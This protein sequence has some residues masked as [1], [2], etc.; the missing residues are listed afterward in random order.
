MLPFHLIIVVMLLLV[1]V[2][3]AENSR[4]S[5]PHIDASYGQSSSKEVRVDSAEAVELP[6]QFVDHVYLDVKV[7][8]HAAVFL[9]D[10]I[11]NIMLDGSFARAQGFS[12]L[13]GV[14][15]GYGSTVT[16]GG[17]GVQRHEVHFVRDLTL[18]LAELSFGFPL[19]PV[20]P[21]D[22]MMSAALG[23][24]VDGLLGIDVLEEFVAEF[25]FPDGM[26]R[27]HPSGFRP[28]E[29]A[30]RLPITWVERR[31]TVPLRF[32]IDGVETEAVFMLD[33]GMSGS[34]R[35]TTRYTN[36]EKLLDRLHPTI[37]NNSERGMGGALASR[38]ARLPRI[39]FGEVDLDSVVVSLAREEE[40]ADAYREWDALLGLDVLSRF[41][42][43][44]D[45]RRDELWLRPNAW[46]DRPFEYVD[47]GLR[48]VP[49]RTAEDGLEVRSVQPNSAAETA[50]FA[51][52]DRIQQFDGE[53]VDGWNKRHWREAL[54][55]RVGRT[56]PVNVQRDGRAVTLRLAV[57]PQL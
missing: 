46:L 54:E 11:R 52:G 41:D 10:P 40:G 27:L 48:F 19:S 36:E 21:L 32:V 17:A 1:P 30:V 33:F 50:A 18:K 14:E 26:L 44:L 28:P 42:M 29:A 6:F 15:A 13:D 23:R 16:T 57:S 47:V 2:S 38:M 4:I 5:R 55:E 7:N 3:R 37:S 39:R 35:F 51:V 20:I 56:V 12:V 43:Y 25:D 49:Q 24:H 45:L 9:Y 31:P 8:G 34:V 53:P 22:S